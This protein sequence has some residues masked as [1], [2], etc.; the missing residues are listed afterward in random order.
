MHVLVSFIALVLGNVPNRLTQQHRDV[1]IVPLQVTSLVK[2]MRQAGALKDAM[3]Y[4]ENCGVRCHSKGNVSFS[5]N[6]FFVS[7]VFFVVLFR[8]PLDVLPVF[9]GF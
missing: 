2:K 1:S 3:P 9:F 8:F 4:P 6:V 7:C 5:L